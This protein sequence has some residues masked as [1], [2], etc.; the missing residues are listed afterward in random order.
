M[1]RYQG[2]TL[3]GPT[4][5]PNQYRLAGAIDVSM[6]GLDAG[7]VLGELAWKLHCVATRVLRG[8]KRAGRR[9]VAVL[10]PLPRHSPSCWTSLWR[11]T[12]KPMGT[13]SRPIKARGPCTDEAVADHVT[14]LMRD[15]L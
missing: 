4:P 9:E 8:P 15:A 12:G 1:A 5:K 13:L 2:T 14:L 10:N 6:I 3:R 11:G 7:G